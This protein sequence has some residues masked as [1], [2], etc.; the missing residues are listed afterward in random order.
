VSSTSRDTLGR[1][2]SSTPEIAGDMLAD[3]GQMWGEATNLY[4]VR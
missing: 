1:Y 3:V 2:T 4:N